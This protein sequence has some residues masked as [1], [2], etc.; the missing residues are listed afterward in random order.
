[1]KGKLKKITALKLAIEASII[2]VWLAMT[3]PGYALQAQTAGIEYRLSDEEQE[4]KNIGTYFPLYYDQLTNEPKLFLLNVD[5]VYRIKIMKGDSVYKWS[6]NEDWP[7][8]P[9]QSDSLVGVIFSAL[10]GKDANVSSLIEGQDMLFLDVD[11]DGSVMKRKGEL[12]PL[13]EA[14][15]IIRKNVYNNG[16]KQ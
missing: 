16:E 7:N 13:E 8:D 12:V 11:D 5:R 2:P 10:N 4:K 14:L 6:T 3:K 15:S 1:M 9:P